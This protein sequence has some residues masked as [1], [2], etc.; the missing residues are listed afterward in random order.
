MHSVSY[1]DKSDIIIF[2]ITEILRNIKSN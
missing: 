2:N 1:K